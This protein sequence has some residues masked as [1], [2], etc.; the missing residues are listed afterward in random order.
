MNIFMGKCIFNFFLHMLG[1][2]VRS[3]LIFLKSSKIALGYYYQYPREVRKSDLGLGCHSGCQAPGIYIV[4]EDISNMTLKFKSIN[5]FWDTFMEMNI[6][7]F[8]LFM[9]ASGQELHLVCF[10]S[11]WHSAS[12]TGLNRHIQNILDTLSVLKNLPVAFFH[13]CKIQLHSTSDSQFFF[14]YLQR[15]CYHKF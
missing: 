3:R 11:I 13:S 15:I 2:C 6:A 5:L 8:S 12:Y 10:P 4:N 9:Y 14:H 1:W 7:Q